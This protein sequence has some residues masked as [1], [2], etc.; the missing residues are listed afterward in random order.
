MKM[1]NVIIAAIIAALCWLS[2]PANATGFGVSPGNYQHEHVEKAPMKMINNVVILSLGPAAEIGASDP[3][4]GIDISDLIG[5]MKVTLDSSAGGGADHT[6]DVK[7]QESDDDSTYTD[8]PSGAFTQVTNAAA[9]F[10]TLTLSADARKKY[11]RIVD[12]VA[13]TSPSFQR[14]V[15]V[16]GEKQYS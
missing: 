12:T 10:Q 9:A 15:T 5:D 6:L 13:G 16:T 1:K 3:V 7:L 11:L 14:S 4:A 2:L 8:V